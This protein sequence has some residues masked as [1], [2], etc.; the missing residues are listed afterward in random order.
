MLSQGRK[1]RG[2]IS[3]G[4]YDSWITALQKLHILGI[5]QKSRWI[6]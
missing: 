1:F 5:C 4:Q 2:N 3:T 6:N